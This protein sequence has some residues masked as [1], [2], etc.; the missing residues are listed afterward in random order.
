ML[1]WGCGQSAAAPGK[2]PSA[3]SRGVALKSKC[4]LSWVSKAREELVPW[5]RGKKT[6]TN[7]A[8]KRPV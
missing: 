1:C 7:P 3:P 6:G 4:H 8:R 5:P 2:K